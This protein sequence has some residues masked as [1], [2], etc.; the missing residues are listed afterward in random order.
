MRTIRL[1]AALVLVL[2]VFCGGAEEAVE[3]PATPSTPAA[4]GTLPAAAFEPLTEAEMDMFIKVLPG[5][6]DAIEAAGYKPE[7]VEG[8][9]LEAS[10][11]R[12][13]GGMKGVAGV[14]DACKK[15]GTT[16]DAFSGS[17]Y[18]VMAGMTALAMD[19]AVAMAEEMG[20]D[21]EVNE[22]LEKAKAF[23]AKVPQANKDMIIAH[24][25]E[26][27]AMEVLQ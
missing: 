15:A 6:A 19:M 13:V 8:E 14:E 10:I 12:V 21:E 2:G 20:G 23:T 1:M 22:E 26:L 7:E 18:K 16:W 27:D 11:A 5:V 17:M 4:G 9:E 25:D 3:Q 24:M